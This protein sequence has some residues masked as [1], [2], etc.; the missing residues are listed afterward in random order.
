M[1]DLYIFA[2]TDYAHRLP[3]NWNADWT[4][5]N[6]FPAPHPQLWS[7]IYPD[8]QSSTLDVVEHGQTPDISEDMFSIVANCFAP[9]YRPLPEFAV[10]NGGIPG[11]SSLVI[12]I[13]GYSNLKHACD[14]WVRQQSTKKRKHGA[15]G[16]IEEAGRGESRF[17]LSSKS[18]SLE[19]QH[20]V[21]L[22]GSC[23]IQ[24]M[25]P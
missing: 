23:F 8:A 2:C 7:A 11:M 21:R 1:T 19:I 25:M 20:A 10:T 22:C 17:R 3:L 24:P 4:S 14:N 12:C 6:S 5:K 13:S 18:G 15:G 9:L 16:E